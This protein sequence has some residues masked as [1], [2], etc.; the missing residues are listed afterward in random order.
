MCF[1]LLQ[2][3]LEHA[4]WH[5]V[6]IKGKFMIYEVSAGDTLYSIAQRFGVS[7]EQIRFDNQLEQQ[8]PLVKGQALLILAEWLPQQT[9]PRFEITGYAYPFIN[10]EILEETLQY[11]NELLV[12]SYGFTTQ[13]EL[14]P[15]KVNDLPLI[16]RA[17]ENGVRPILVL[18]PFDEN[19]RFNNYLVKL[20]VQDQQMQDRLIENLLNTVQ[21]Q[22]YAGVDVD[23]EYILPEDKQGY[24]EFVGNL[25][26][27]MNAQGYQVSVALAPKT[28][29]EQKGLLYEGMDYRL[30]GENADYVFLMT[31]EW[32]YTYGPPMAVAPL[33]KVQEVA[34]Y[35]VTE[36]PQEKIMLGVPN[37]AYDW[38]L[39]FQAGI[40]AAELIGNVEAVQRAA[41]RAE[42]IL[43]D[44]TAQSPHFTYWE[45]EEQHE[46][47]FE[48]VRSIKAK[49][50]LA[51]DYGL[52]GVGYWNLMRPF[53]ANWLLL[54][55]MLV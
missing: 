28:H 41:Y 37:Y 13:G 44:S 1:I 22:G 21:M 26:A 49:L 38:K 31:Y 35:A 7:V 53:R 10:K 46:V 51:S 5:I 40:S 9:I 23:F 29:A 20:V 54:N 34:D 19:D 30:L 18:T 24:G 11:I 15:P 48:D 39:P 17:W 42:E 36:I 4:W 45:G 55:N 2:E 50:Q 25:R 3:E 47:W 12:F 27:A 43:F 16:Q 33:N 32:G 14:I 8:Q 52:R 6:K